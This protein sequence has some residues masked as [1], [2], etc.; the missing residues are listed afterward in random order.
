MKEPKSGV[1]N[2][3]G[4]GTKINGKLKVE[5]SVHIDGIIEGN[6]EISELLIIGKSGRIQGEIHTRDC[7]SGGK[8]EGNLYSDGRVEFKTGASLK[9]DLKC[10]HLI[11]E[12][13]VVF[14]GSCKMSE[15]PEII[16]K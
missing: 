11:V 4:K 1:T 16:K 15:K 10:K 12:E 2:I 9:G 13:G 8:I 5:G 14:D 7:F 6:V 3:L